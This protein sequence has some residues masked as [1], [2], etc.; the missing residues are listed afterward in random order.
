[1]TKQE[2]KSVFDQYFDDLRAYVFYR[3]GDEE[4]STDI[5]QDVFM[6]IWEKQVAWE[7][8]KTL[9]LLYKMASN[10]FVSIY[11][12]RKL[13]LNYRNTLSLEIERVNPEEKMRFNEMQDRYEKALSELT[14][15]QRIVF[16]MSRMDGLKYFEIADRL[17]I[18][19]KAVE[20]RMR[21]ALRDLKMKLGVK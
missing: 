4:L 13:E 7:G 16:L 6:K 15:K 20:K 11:R 3:S 5:A 17:K 12:R 14:E 2:F 18:S 1:M 19:V 9:A 8:K 10:Q 21:F